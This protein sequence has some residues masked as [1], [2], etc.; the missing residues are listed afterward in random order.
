MEELKLTTEN[1]RRLYYNSETL[2]SIKKELEEFTSSTTFSTSPSFP[3][4][5]L[6]PYE[7]KNNNSIEGYNE[8]LSSIIKIINNPFLRSSKINDEYQRVYNLFNGYEYI[9]KEKNINKNTLR[10]LYEILSYGLLND[11]DLLREGKNYRHDDVYIFYSTNLARKPDLGFNCNNIEPH[12]NELFEYINTN[13]NLS[14]V[15]LFIKSQIIHFYMVFIH[16]YFDINGR[17]ARTTSLW[18]LNKNNNFSYTIFNRGIPYNKNKYYRAIR[19]AKIYRN[20]TSFIMLISIWTKE[21]L[22]KEY[23]IRSMDKS[24]YSSLSPIEKQVIQYILTNKSINTL[25]DIQSFY[26]RFNPPKK[27]DFI[28]DE[29]LEPLFKKDILLKGNITEKFISKIASNNYRF[30]L[31]PDIFNYDRT[32]IK[33][34]TPN[35]Y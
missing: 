15:D 22:E 1:N 9:L 26:N 29:L 14:D 2:K 4:E 7:L 34:L 27:V 33:R 21:E 18:F 16:P 6:F 24:I 12:M 35:K 8:D 13:N 20:L 10:K 23:I 17:C 30:S 11:S 5:I 32:K 3:K 28:N 19:E 31:N 25:I